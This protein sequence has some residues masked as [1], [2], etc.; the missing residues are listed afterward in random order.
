MSEIH[1]KKSKLASMS[2]RHPWIFSGAIAYKDKTVSDGDLVK[3]FCDKKIIGSGHYQKGSI[4]IRLLTYDD[5][6]VDQSWW[7]QKIDNAYKLRTTLSIISESTDAFRLIHGEGDGLPGLIIDIYRSTA[8]VQ[9]HSA[10][11]YASAK[12]IQE[13]LM[14]SPLD[15]DTIYLQVQNTVQKYFPDA[16]NT[17]LLG[18]KEHT[19]VVEHGVL[20][21]VNWVKGQKTGFFLDQRDNRHYLMHHSTDKTVL[22]CFCYSGGFSL[23]ALKGG[24]THV[25]SVDISKTAT[26]LVHKNHELNDGKHNHTI[27]TE[28][29]MDH[30]SASANMYDIVVI[31][32]P[33]FAKNMNKRHNAV[34]AYKRLNIMA[35]KRVLP[36]GL[37]YTFSCSQ[38]VDKELFEHTVRS[39]AIE[40]GK[41]MQIVKYLSQGS[42]HPVNIYHPEGHYL[43]GLIVRLT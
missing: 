12:Y 35:M 25:T 28:N 11:M 19:T 23:Y 29:V 5:T 20:F 8:V 41:E 34:Q 2:R 38:V 17:F 33:A 37:L 32:P 26:D 18:S 31:D 10:G 42:D 14:N 6:V 16:E 4:A 24:A 30:L 15:I 36:G 22:N 1:L 3:V 27:L 9:C 40:V 39:A 7:N 21:D 43:K 13:A